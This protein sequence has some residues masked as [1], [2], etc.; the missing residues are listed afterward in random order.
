MKV[1]WL[2]SAFHSRS[3]YADWFLQRIFRTHLKAKVLILVPNGLTWGRNK[4][5]ACHRERRDVT[6]NFWTLS[7]CLSSKAFIVFHTAGHTKS[8]GRKFIAN[9]SHLHIPS[10]CRFVHS[11]KYSDGRKM[12]SDKHFIWSILS[13]LS[14]DDIDKN[15]WNV[16]KSDLHVSFSSIVFCGRL[17]MY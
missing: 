5:P 6:N 15:K 17:M 4:K 10:D 13:S 2:A 11:E 12:V 16:S 3:Q 1:G 14:T 7:N 8:D 9:I